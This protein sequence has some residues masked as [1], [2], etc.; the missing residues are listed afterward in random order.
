MV[1]VPAID[2][3]YPCTHQVLYPSTHTD[4]LPKWGMG[5]NC[6]ERDDIPKVTWTIQ[7]KAIHLSIK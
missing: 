6:G 7:G 4:Q 5:I 3:L 1:M 2:V